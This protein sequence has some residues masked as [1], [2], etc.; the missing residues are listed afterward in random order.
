VVYA[1]IDVGKGW[2]DLA[3]LNLDGQEGEAG[4]DR[5]KEQ[6]LLGKKSKESKKSDVIEHY[7]FN[8]NPPGRESLV[9]LLLTRRPRQVVLEASGI[10]HLPLLALLLEADVA[11]FLANPYQVAAFRRAWGA[12]NKTDSQDA[13]LLARFAKAY[14]GRLE[15]RLPPPAKLAYLK[16]LL[17]Y[18][19]QLIKRATMIKGS[20]EAAIWVVEA[21]NWGTEAANRGTEAAGQ[22][23][24]VTSWK[25][26]EAV[27]QERNRETGQGQ[28][29]EQGGE[30]EAERDGGA[31]QDRDASQILSWL[32]E[33]LQRVRERLSE[34]AQEINRLLSL[35]PEAAV[36]QEQKGVGPQVAAAVLAFLPP[37]LWGSP[38]RAASFSGLIPEQQHSG[39]SLH[40]S[41]LSKKGP[42]LL[43]KKLYLAALVAVK[44]DPEMQAFY[45]RL[46]SRGKKRKQAL[47]AVAHKL[48]RR[49]TGRLKAYYREQ[50]QRQGDDQRQGRGQKQ[51]QGRKRGHKQNC[52]RGC[53]ENYKESCE[54]RHGPSDE[55]NNERN[56]EPSNEHGEL[57]NEQGYD[58]RQAHRLV[59][60][61]VLEVVEVDGVAG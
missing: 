52:E 50:G 55:Q 11:A 29:A 12:R 27:G 4:K 32:K 46:L 57:S 33:D 36:L 21:A 15:R 60:K 30:Q 1:G 35:L 51:S 22:T 14:E 25:A 38:K 23:T 18:R 53:Q 2:L 24:E 49:L 3:L 58:D 41:R 42:A 31:E 7:R 20:I 48:L 28:V 17:V 10:Y 43:R 61:Q 8:N 47:L 45:L 54:P 16:R 39:S 26:E 56:N 9:K 59:T 19:E 40:R 37:A 6:Q 44:H 5:A 34:V 13:V